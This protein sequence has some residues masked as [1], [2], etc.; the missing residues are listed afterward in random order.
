MEKYHLWN[1]EAMGSCCMALGTMP[2][3]LWQSM[4]MWEKKNVY[5]YMWLG[6]LAMQQKIDRTL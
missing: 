5:M 1:V 4:I 6:H 2:G 3:H